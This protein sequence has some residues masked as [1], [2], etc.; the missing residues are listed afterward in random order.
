MTTRIVIHAGFHK[1]GTTSVQSMLRENASV[2]E[3]H[4][5]VFLKEAFDGLT[6][7][8]RAFSIDPKK[9]TLAA[10]TRAAVAFFE[11][12][13]RKDPR[14]I[15]MSSEDLSGHM[16]GRHGLECYDSAGLVMKC[17]S[18]AAFRRFG[19]DTDLTFYFSTR[20][21]EPWLRS[22]WWQNLRS[23]R[24]T[25][26]FETYSNQFDAAR[27]LDDILEEI[28]HD[29]APARV[30]SFLLEDAATLPLGPLDPLV[31]LLELTE[32]DRD[33][34]VVLP[35]ENVQPDLGIDAVFLALNRSE[36]PE[37]DVQDAKRIVRKMAQRPAS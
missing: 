9:K 17:L 4:V 18:D 28:A 32:L 20:M 16:P 12:V 6:E 21:R 29:V 13:D 31:T 33:A 24:L 2:L 30:T 34:V 36:L 25:D 22:T 23:T 14:P 35:P 15:L 19:N 1:T 5:R 3:P 11:T 8:A 7:S 37:R 27:S 10:V 26:D